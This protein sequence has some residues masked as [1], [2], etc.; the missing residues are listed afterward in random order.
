MLDQARA[1]QKEGNRRMRS[2]CERDEQFVT[3]DGVQSSERGDS[4][5][6]TVTK[7][8]WFYRFTI[9]RYEFIFTLP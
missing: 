4:E 5:L 8:T 9:L 2:G 7:L 3:S 6:W 1:R